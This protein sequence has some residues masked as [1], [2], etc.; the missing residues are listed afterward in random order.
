MSHSSMSGS[1][2]VTTSLWVLGSLRPFLFLILSSSVYSPYFLL[3]SSASVRSLMFLS[4]IVPIFA[5]NVPLISSSFLKRSVVFPIALFSPISLH[6]SL[7][8]AF[9]PLTYLWNFAFSLMYLSLSPLLS[10]VFFP[11]LFVRIPQETTLPSCIS[12]LGDGFGHHLLYN[13]IN[14]CP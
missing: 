5:W 2:W 6:Y 10:L 12:F 14:L 3:L 1:R 8:K 13:V 4:F 9:L 11:L 7:R